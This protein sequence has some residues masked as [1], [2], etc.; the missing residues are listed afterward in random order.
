[1][2]LIKFNNVSFTYHQHEALS[3]INFEVNEGDYVGVI[4]PNG[5]GKTTLLRLLLGLLHPQK[6]EIL[7]L[8]EPVVTGHNTAQIGYLPQK[9]TQAETRFPMTVEEVVQ[10]G[11][12]GSKTW[13]P[14]LSSAQ[15]KS[16][17][18]ALDTVG[19]SEYRRHLVSELS[20]GQQQRVFI[21]KALA[22]KPKLLILD[23]PTVGIDVEAQAQFYLLLKKLNTELGMTIVLVTHDI[24]VVVNEVTT[25][26]CV[27]QTLI[28]HG[29]SDNFVKGD[30]LAKLYGQGK[31]FVMHAH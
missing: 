12:V 27:N 14:F 3:D 5:S 13:L 26:L 28:Y 29:S 2:Q 10:L 6:G 15:H 25:V 17:L 4:G 7:L 11:C 24:D 22:G 23:E 1:M 9:I 20:G 18:N 8:G 16:V 21:A 30:Y 31:K 19:L